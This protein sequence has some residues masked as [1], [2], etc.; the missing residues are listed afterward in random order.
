MADANEAIWAQVVSRGAKRAAAKAKKAEAEPP[1]PREERQ[2]ARGPRSQQK[3]E[4]WESGRDIK[5][6]EQCRG[7]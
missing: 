6:G 4:R 2:A 5:K 1:R 7:A 3:G